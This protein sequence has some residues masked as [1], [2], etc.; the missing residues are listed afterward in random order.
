MTIANK[1]FLPL[2]RMARG[3]AV[4]LAA[5][6]CLAA[7]HADSVL[8]KDSF[9]TG[10]SGRKVGA[11][12][13]GLAP[14]QGQGRWSVLEGV[15]ATV[16][17]EQGTVLSMGNGSSAEARIA[18]NEPT[19]IVTVSAR[20]LVGTADWVAVGLLASD[21]SDGWLAAD[22][23]GAA[24]WLLLRSNGNWTLFSRGTAAQLLAGTSAAYPSL[25]FNFD[26]PYTIGL[27]Y[28]PMSGKVRPFISD[29]KD[30][31]NLFGRDSGWLSARLPENAKIGGAGFR[32]NARAG[33]L[34][35][36]AWVDEFTVTEAVDGVTRFTQ[37]PEALRSQ[38]ALGT[39]RHTRDIGDSPFGI[40]TTVL[41]EGGSFN[42][43]TMERLADLIADGGFKWAVDYVASGRTG[44]MTLA[45]VEEKFARLPERFF[46]YPQMLRDRGVNLLVRIDPMPWAPMGKAAPYDYE[47][48]SQDMLKAK[49]FVRQVVRQL[50]PYTNHWQ[51]WNEPNIGNANPFITPENYVKVFAQLAEVIREEQPDAVLYGPG[52][53]MLQCMADTPYPWI[54]RVL[55]A[56]L[57][58]Y[59]DVFTFHPYRQPA[60]RENLPEY[61]S[62]FY[63]WQIWKTYDNQMAE[64]KEMLSKHSKDGSPVRWAAT[65]D[66]MPDLINGA[67]E[68]P[69]TWVVSA[70]YELRR[71]LQDFWH[72]VNP[73]TLFCLYRPIPDVFYHGQSSYSVVTSDFQKKPAYNA[74]QNL[75]SVL[76]NS[77]VRA[78]SVPVVLEALGQDKAAPKGDLRVQTYIKDHGEFEEL[79]V[80]YW[81][82][83]ASGDVHARYPARLRIDEQGWQA[84]LQIDLM[85]MPVPRPK[86]APVAIID[87][88]FVDRRDPEV[89]SARHGEQGPVIDQVEIRDYPMLVKWVRPK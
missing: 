49:A 19:G 61:S 9:S 79:L 46:T 25:H 50:K 89:L 77:Y 14:E 45:Q 68:Q 6:G 23:K 36:S 3:C 12:L 11:T 81:S 58:D 32:I 54:P 70:K 56:G 43:K 44:D 88:K 34:S 33:T 57:L 39:P 60:V 15:N 82:A 10:G 76:D 71:A 37:L 18:I 20:V 4:L 62:E 67:G 51:I 21:K 22:G 28:D 38:I 47:P 35:G 72:G 31:A 53:A 48:D 69:V 24:L 27:S 1:L 87:S 73:R 29:G 74:A 78:D 52:T 42:T 84:P 75:N 66:G 65:E 83:E 30:E 59:V 80:F 2:S 64:L 7:V 26:A 8:V 86:N 17:S 40:H 55:E 85:A 41:H 63:P 13:N 5:A 16:L